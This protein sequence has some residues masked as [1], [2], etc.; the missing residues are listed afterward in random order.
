[1]SPC[2]ILYEKQPMLT[3][4]CVRYVDRQISVIK[5]EMRQNYD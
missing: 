2:Q 5:K 3:T 1:M 4:E